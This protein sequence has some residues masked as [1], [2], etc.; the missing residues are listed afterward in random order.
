[1]A[2]CAKQEGGANVTTV[3]LY[4]L[5]LY[6]ILHAVNKINVSEATQTHRMMNWRY[7]FCS[8]T[9]QNRAPLSHDVLLLVLC[10]SIGLE[11]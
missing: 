3:V 1:M 9:L 5:V 7:L 10:L 2:I 11:G 4:F 8:Q 6:F